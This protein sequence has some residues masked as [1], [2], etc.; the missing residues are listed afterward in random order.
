M[1]VVSRKRSCRRQQ[2]FP[3]HHP[4]RIIDWHP[5][6]SVHVDA[7]TVFFYVPVKTHFDSRLCWFISCSIQTKQQQD[8]SAFIFLVELWRSRRISYYVVLRF[9][10]HGNWLHGLSLQVCFE[11][12]SGCMP[13]TAL[14][15]HTT[16]RRALGATPSFNVPLL[17]PVVTYSPT[18]FKANP[19]P[20]VNLPHFLICCIVVSKCRFNFCFAFTCIDAKVQNCV[21]D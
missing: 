10:V 18:L 14:S 20:T 4:L 5:P 6:L 3:N 19:F 7:H 8:T 15:P 2:K 12:I 11:N 16:V 1:N 13:P 9:V 21:Y 17:S